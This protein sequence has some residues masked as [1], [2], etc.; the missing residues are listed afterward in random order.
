MAFGDAQIIVLPEDNK[1][2]T[3]R[4]RM[5]SILFKH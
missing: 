4:L 5:P 2:Q 3:L 1:L